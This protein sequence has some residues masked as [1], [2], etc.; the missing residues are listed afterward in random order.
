MCSRDGQLKSKKEQFLT[1]FKDRCS[2]NEQSNDNTC[3]R[4][5]GD[6][7]CQTEKSVNMQPKKPKKDM[8]S[9]KSAMKSSNRK[10]IGLNKNCK[11]TICE[12]TDSKS[13]V[14]RSY[15]KNCQEN[16]VM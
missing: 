12:N 8:Q 3:T 15:D 4:D 14:S 9:E 7:N 10:S 1:E 6:K 11:A 2:K 13:Q 16:N 5:K